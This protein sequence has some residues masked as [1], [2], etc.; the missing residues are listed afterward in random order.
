MV[1]LRPDKFFLVSG[2]AEGPTLLNAFDNAL[3]NAG[4]GNTNLI[5]ISSIL[6]PAA[7][8]IPPIAL[9]Y[10]A[11]VPIAYS[12]ESSDK[13]GTL[14]SAAVACG[15]PDDPK[16]PGVIMEYHALDTEQNCLEFVRK[17]VEAAFE[18]RGFRLANVK[19]ASASGIV[20]GTGSAFAAV[21]LWS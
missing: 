20:K 10:G 7:T 4:I 14:V 1:F 6:P 9:P 13:P 18:V 3:M 2:Y 12:Y 19:Q 8:E 11:L 17:Q 21:V 5:R 15:I 16:L